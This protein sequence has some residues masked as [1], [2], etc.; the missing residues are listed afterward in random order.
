MVQ[1]SKVPP[2][3][4]VL[5]WQSLPADRAKRKDKK[6]LVEKVAG[7]YGALPSSIYRSMR[8][9][10]DAYRGRA[11]DLPPEERKRQ[12][13]EG[14]YVMGLPLPPLEPLPP[15]PIEE[16]FIRPPTKEEL[17]SGRYRARRVSCG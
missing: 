13:A 16:V 4:L 6:R 1:F 2:A 15:V 10:M 12:E 3:V 8:R 9:H 14:R 11:N 5:L 17:M 7:M